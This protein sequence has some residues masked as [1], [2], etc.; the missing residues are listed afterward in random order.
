MQ[1]KSKIYGLVGFPLE[2][3]FSQSFFNNKFEKEGIDAY[4]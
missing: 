3:S 1:R 2:H 4:Y